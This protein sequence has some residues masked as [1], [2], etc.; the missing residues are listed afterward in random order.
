LPPGSSNT[1]LQTGVFRGRTTPLYHTGTGVSN[2]RWGVA[3]G[4]VVPMGDVIDFP[5]AR[6]ISEPRD[7]GSTAKVLPFKPRRQACLSPF[8]G[9]ESRG[10]VLLTDETAYFGD[11]ARPSHIAIQM[12]AIGGGV[13]DWQT[14]SGSN[15]PMF[16]P[17]G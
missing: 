7:L 5:F 8:A 4:I 13:F 15:E 10:G 12:T 16:P 9:I 1:W 17:S 11:P 14:P 2:L 3:S 6:R